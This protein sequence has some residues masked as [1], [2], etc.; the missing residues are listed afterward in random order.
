MRISSDGLYRLFSDCANSMATG[1]TVAVW[2][3]ITKTPHPDY[4]NTSIFLIQ[5]GD[6]IPPYEPL[7][8]Y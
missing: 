6:E 3:A 4:P 8:E 1:A 2:D 7:D 5:Y